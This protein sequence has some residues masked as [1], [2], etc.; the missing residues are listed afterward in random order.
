MDVSLIISRPGAA[1]VAHESFGKGAVMPK[2][3]ETEQF[4]ADALNKSLR[5]E[6]QINHLL[7]FRQF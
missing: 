5:R 2:A 3:K 4:A 7:F 1:G 6:N